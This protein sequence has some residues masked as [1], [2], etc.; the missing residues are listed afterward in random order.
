MDSLGCGVSQIDF[1]KIG[2]AALSRARELLPEWLPGGR[3][4]GR[5]YV[6]GNLR[7]DPGESLKI[8]IQTGVGADFATGET[9]GDLIAV[10]AAHEGIGQGEAAKRLAA[11]CGLNGSNGSSHPSDSKRI[12]ST[13]RPGERPSP[14]IP[15]PQE[16]LD[17]TAPPPDAAPPDFK[18]HFGQATEFWTYRDADGAPLFHVARYEPKGQ[19]KQFVPWSWSQTK[20]GWVLK[21]W[22]APR[23]LYGLDRLTKYPSRPVLIVEGE[24]AAEA[25]QRI[26]GQKYVVVTWSGGAASAARTQWKP[27]AGRKCLLWPDADSTH[28]YPKSHARADQTCDYLDQPGPKAM[29]T[30]ADH[31]AG[32]CP[33]IKI[34]DVKD[35]PDG[36]D[37]A[38]AEGEGW[39]FEKLTLW[40][41]PRVHVYQWTSPEQELPSV[42]QEA[43]HPE[44]IHDGPKPLAQPMVHEPELVEPER[45]RE[46]PTTIVYADMEGALDPNTERFWGLWARL[47]IQVSK[48]NSPVINLDN[49][50]KVLERHEPLRGLL[51]YDE[52]E[53]K[54]LTTWHSK[55]VR[56]WSKFDTLELSRLLQSEIGFFKLTDDLVF[57]AATLHAFQNKR[58]EL[59]EWLESLTHDG[60]P[61]VETFFHLYMGA[62]LSDHHL[63][64]S[65][66]FWVSMVARVY[67]PGCKV[68]NMVVLESG[69][70]KFKSTALDAI[71]GKWFTEAHDSVT[72]KD[73][74]MVLHGKLLVEI[75]EMDAFSKAEIS[76]IKKTITNRKDRFRPPYGAVAEDFPRQGIFAG[77]TNESAY[78]RDHTGGRRFWPVR[79][80]AIDIECIRRDRSQL[81]AEAVSL[82]KAGH[83]WWEMPKTTA[84]EQEERLQTDSWDDDVYAFISRQTDTTLKDIWAQALSGDIAKLSRADELRLGKILHRAGWRSKPVRRFGILSKRWFPSNGNEEM[85]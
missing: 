9:F 68:D 42:V 11:R 2:E 82:Y 76:T 40:A 71:G 83:T 28:T 51:W 38:D 53:R 46:T 4:V 63:A 52:F 75:S 26:V 34:L 57:K 62:R 37:A 73:F 36:F 80:G 35:M 47:G 22:P 32:L 20:P 33:E 1:E 27:V 8:N 10:Y 39:D 66:N 13:L 69:Q 56:E 14:Q 7:G 50:L 64:A 12:D 25:A 54:I 21:S 84:E 30:L 31:L 65:K 24:R 16:H 17:L 67:D 74:F 3:I 5:E 45:L 85:N 29:Y 79:I 61:R 60:V 18:C 72:N 19:R 43:T 49:V 6:C 78:L 48:T 70:G 77:T 59:K 44:P 23:P 15:H 81:F 41:R 58:N 55:E